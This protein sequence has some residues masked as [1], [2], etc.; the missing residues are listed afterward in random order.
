MLTDENLL[1]MMGQSSRRV[2]GYYPSNTLINKG[3]NLFTLGWL[4]M[5]IDDWPFG[6][7]ID[8]ANYPSM[9]QS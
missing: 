4:V 2:L 6:V 5:S 3:V 1:S 9:S 7:L 8:G